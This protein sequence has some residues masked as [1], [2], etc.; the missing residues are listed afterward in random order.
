MPVPFIRLLKVTL[1]LLAPQVYK[2]ITQGGIALALGKAS[3]RQYPLILLDYKRHIVSHQVQHKE[4]E[5]MGPS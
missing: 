2:R 4:V 1:L 5:E 3:V